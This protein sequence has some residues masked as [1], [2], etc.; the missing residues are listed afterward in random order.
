MAESSS[1]S[2]KS[3]FTGIQK[4]KMK[5]VSIDTKLAILES[6]SIGVS[7]ANLAK[8]YEVPK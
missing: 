7:Q 6:L 3:S 2:T 5:V 8:Q 1:T 4:K